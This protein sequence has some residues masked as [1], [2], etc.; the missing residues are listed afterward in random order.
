M[1]QILQSLTAVLLCTVLFSCQRWKPVH[2]MYVMESRISSVEEITESALS[3]FDFFYL[4]APPKWHVEDFDQDEEW[5]LQKYVLDHKYSRPEVVSRFVETAH[6]VGASV[7]CSF[8]GRAFVDIA[9]DSLRR[10]KFAHMA[11]AF[12]DKYGY[13]G[14]ELD[15]EH[16]IT[17]ELHVEM[18]EAFRRAL[19][20]RPDGKRWLTTALNTEQNHYSPELAERLQNVADWINLM[21]YDMGGGEWGTVPSHNAPLDKIRENYAHNWSHFRPEKIHIG[22]ANYGYGYRGIKPGEEVEPGKTLAD[23]FLHSYRPDFKNGWTEVWDETAEC[24]YFFSPDGECFM[25][26]ENE[27][28]VRAKLDWIR[29][30]GFGGIFWWEFHC[31]WVPPK[32]TGLRGTHLVTDT[33]TD[34][35]RRQKI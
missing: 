20:G 15:W 33:A 19:S 26:V 4:V 7:L 13:D 3:D 11:A 29:G 34:Y 28:S 21:Y 12:A 16:T 5:I 17:P 30:K 22:L 9:S 10:E 31:D 25:S 27:R 8:P 14:I 23:Y 24:P 18:M 35:L 1:K 32:K 6:K 2:A